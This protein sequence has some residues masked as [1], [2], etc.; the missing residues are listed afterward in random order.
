VSQIVIAEEDPRTPDAAAMMA[1]LDARMRE[2][3][4]P[5]TCHLASAETL[6]TSG[7]VFLVARDDG[8]A[9]GCVALM[10]IE[11]GIGEIKR[12]WTVPE[13][14]GRG[15][16]SALLAAI[17]AAARARRMPALMLETSDK[18]PDA[19][20]LFRKHG[21]VERGPYGGYCNDPELIF[22]EKS[23]ATTDTESAA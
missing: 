21:F 8:R 2:L 12:V 9:V 15:V 19:V 7:S 16:A 23:L 18:Q 20:G 3:Y 6:L 17:E 1:A 13:A 10:P 11:D 5:E 4:R 22:M 14:R